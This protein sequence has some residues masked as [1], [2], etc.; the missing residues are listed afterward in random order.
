MVETFETFSS[1]FFIFFRTPHPFG[2]LVPSLPTQLAPSLPT[3]L[4]IRRVD[5]RVDR[6]DRVV[7]RVV[8]VVDRVVR[9]VY[10][11]VRVVDRVGHRV[12]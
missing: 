7:D 11:V 4:P 2:S 1:D 3:S 12:H 10:R 5:H 6:V 8:R 9:V